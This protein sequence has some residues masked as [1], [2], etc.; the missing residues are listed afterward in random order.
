RSVPFCD[1]TPVF[2]TCGG[3]SCHG[4]AG[5]AD[6]PSGGVHLLTSSDP[7]VLGQ[8]LLDVPA[9]YAANSF[10][11]PP[12]PPCPTGDQVE[13]YIDSRD[14]ARSVVLTKVKGDG[15][16]AC[17]APRP[18]FALP[19]ADIQCIEAWVQ[20]VVAEGPASP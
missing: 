20:A 6:E 7:M 12:S 2:M 4:I 8:S 16:F 14:P 11:I 13:R 9:K 18:G 17:G 5:S 19:A 10:P 1:P 3:F 15:H